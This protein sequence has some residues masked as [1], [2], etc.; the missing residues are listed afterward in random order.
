MN[1]IQQAYKGEIG[2]WKYLII[3]IG[4]TGLMVLNYLAIKLLNLDVNEIMRQEIER[5]GEIRVLIETLMPLAIGLVLLLLWVKF[6]HKQSLTSLTTAR[7]KI[8]WKR[9]FF[10][11]FLWGILSSSMVLLQYF[12]TPEDFV[13]NF[14]LK[15]FV[16]LAIVSILLIPLQ[17]SFEEY[18]FRGYLIQG[19]GAFFKNSW[20]PLF[21]TSIVFGLM[22]LGNPEVGELGPVIMTYYIGTGFFLG[23]ITLMDDGL[24]LALGFHA[25]NNL[26]T[27]LLVTTDWTAFQTPSILRNT[28]EPTE[29]S[30]LEVIV[31]VFVIFPILIF[32]FSKIYKWNNWKEKLFGRVEPPFDEESKVNMIGES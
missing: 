25:A 11:F 13:Y 2:F 27:A 7:K 28:A 18:L 5:K 32:I 16:Y 12:S 21:F 15:P 22:H 1:Y 17:T 4:F 20:L 9:I 30:M 10:A 6:I 24:E 31:P 8:D 3:P 26:F 19:I 23:I 29:I 14:K